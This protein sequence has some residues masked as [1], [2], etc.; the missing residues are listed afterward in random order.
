MI[1]SDDLRKKA[2]QAR[3]AASIRTRGGQA[4]DR[5]LIEMAYRLEIQADDMDRRRAE[6]AAICRK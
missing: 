6:L 5:R 2:A 4:A 1:S 3:K